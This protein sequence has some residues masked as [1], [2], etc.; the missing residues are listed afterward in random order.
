VTYSLDGG[1][2]LP[3]EGGFLDLQIP[4]GAHKLVLRNEK[5]C[6]DFVQKIEPGDPAKELLVRL[7]FKPTSVRPS[8]PQAKVI[9]VNGNVVDSGVA[10]D[11]REF[12]QGSKEKVQ[13]DFYVGDHRD[14]QTVTVQAG[15]PTTEVTCH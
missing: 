9:T 1:P 14:Q 7:P 12:T 15:A 2:F 13:V 11:I 4:A 5:C 8:C 3:I 6:E 10:V